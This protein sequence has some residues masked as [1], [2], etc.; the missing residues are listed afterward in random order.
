MNEI[1]WI[2]RLDITHTLALILFI[3]SIVASLASTI[4]YLCSNGQSIC[5]ANH[6]YEG[7]AKENREY[8]NVS[9]RILKKYCIMIFHLV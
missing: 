8:A 4:F 6:G 3:I 1:Y 9:K 7:S 5:D 2:T